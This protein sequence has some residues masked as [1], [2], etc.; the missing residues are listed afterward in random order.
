MQHL[1]SDGTHDDTQKTNT[2]N[3]L[4]SLHQADDKSL[5]I[6]SRKKMSLRKRDSC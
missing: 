4:S 2:L 6:L 3:I 1:L 5:H